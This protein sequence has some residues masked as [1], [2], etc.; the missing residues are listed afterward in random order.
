VILGAGGHAGA[1]IDVIGQ[2]GDE[3]VAMAG[4][5]DREWP[6]RLVASDDEGIALAVAEDAAIALAVGSN[7][8]R[9]A[10]LGL[11][12]VSE[13]AHPLESPLAY[14]ST[15]AVLGRGVVVMSGVHIG[16]GAAVADGALINT[17][18]VVEHDSHVGAG[19]HVAPGAVL[20]GASNVGERCLVGAR[21]VVLPGVVVGDDVTVGAGSVVI[22]DLPGPTMV[23]GN[24]ARPLRSAAEETS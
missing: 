22:D 6:H 14:V 5:P 9:L 17:H 12:G 19:A 4:V 15:T 13:R 21:S 7:S 20:L 2:R 23:A 1:V 24:P 18:A 16:P 3:V 11:T 10:L 8:A